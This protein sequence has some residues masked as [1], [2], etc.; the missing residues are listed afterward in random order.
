MRR[1][2]YIAYAARFG[3]QYSRSH[4]RINLRRECKRAGIEKLKVVYS[5]EEPLRPIFPEGDGRTP[6]SV[7]LVPAAAGILIANEVFKEL[8]S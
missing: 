5:V 6:G 3:I 1:H 4:V 7:A 2:G 8:L